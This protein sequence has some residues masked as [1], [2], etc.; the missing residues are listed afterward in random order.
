MKINAKS[1]GICKK[2]QP[3]VKIYGIH[4]NIWDAFVLEKKRIYIPYSKE[5]KSFTYLPPNRNKLFKQRNEK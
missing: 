5:K 3:P 1:M 2:L 4:A